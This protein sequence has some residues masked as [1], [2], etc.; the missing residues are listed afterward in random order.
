MRAGVDCAAGGGLRDD[1]LLH[2]MV[3][4]GRGLRLERRCAIGIE[5]QET[6]VLGRSRGASKTEFIS[7]AF[8]VPRVAIR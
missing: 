1:A 8:R 2:N 4:T 6:D 3:A 5:T 7:L